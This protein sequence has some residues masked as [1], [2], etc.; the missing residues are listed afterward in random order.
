[1]EAVRTYRENIHKEF[2][3]DKCAKAVIKRGKLDHSQNLILDFNR[4]IK[5]LKR[6]K[7]Y[8]YLGHE[9]SEGKQHQQMKETFQKEHQEIKNYN[10]IRAECQE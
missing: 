10:E 2:G 4:K 6:G 9:E 8:K 1:M 3:L 7:I 5:E